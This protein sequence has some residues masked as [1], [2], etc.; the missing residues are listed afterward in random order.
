MRSLALIAVFVIRSVAN[1]QKF[2]RMKL[3]GEEIPKDY[4]AST[5]ILCKSIQAELFYKNPDLYKSILGNVKSR[6]F[7]S[8]ESNGDSGSVL[9][10][11]YDH[12]IEN[13]AFIEGLLWG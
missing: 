1:A 13:N 4:K 3:I 7:Q 6:D 2:E 5:E 8:F 9:Y 10:F 11:E 12:K